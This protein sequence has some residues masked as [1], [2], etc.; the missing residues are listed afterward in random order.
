MLLEYEDEL[1]LPLPPVEG[2]PSIPAGGGNLP[3]EDSLPFISG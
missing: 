3:R 2:D 1:P